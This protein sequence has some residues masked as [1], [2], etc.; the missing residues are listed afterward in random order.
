MQTTRLSSR[1]SLL[2]VLTIALF[3]VTVGVTVLWMGMQLNQRAIADSRKMIK[4]GIDDLHRQVAV[5]AIDYSI[6][7]T[8]YNV[9]IARDAAQI[10]E[11]F[12]S[13]ATYGDAF[14]LLALTD[15]PFEGVQSWIAEGPEEP[16]PD[17]VPEP[18]IAEARRLVAEIPLG[19]RTTAKFF[20][21]VGD[22]VYAFV[23]ARVQPHEM[24]AAGNPATETMPLAVFGYAIGEEALAELA[25][26][27]LLTDLRLTNAAP[28]GL[29]SLPLIGSDGT[30][31]AHVT[32]SPPTPGDALLERLG[33]PLVAVFL[34][35][36][37]IAG[38][39]TATARRNARKLIEQEARAHRA[40]RTDS[41]TVLPNRLALTEAM[42][43]AEDEAGSLAL[44]FMDINGFK[45]VN[46]TVGHKGGDELIAQ[47]SERLCAIQPP[48][49][50]LGR[51]SGD[52]FVMMVRGED[53]LKRAMTLGSQ[54]R[55]MLLPEFLVSGRTFHITVAIGVSKRGGE[56]DTAAELLRKADLAMYH[57]KRHGSPEPT[58]Y[59]ATFES[60]ARQKK[61]V[62]EAL[63]R[64]LHQPDDFVVHYHP[65]VDAHDGRMVKA[66]A[67][68]RWS[69]DTLGRIEPGVFITVAEETGLI[70]PLGKILIQKI[71]QDLTEWPELR[72]A[73]N[74]SPA[75]LNDAEF[76]RETIGTLREMNV[77]PSRIEIELT[78]GLIV[79]N[80]DMAAF[81]LDLLHEAGFATSLDDFGTGFS[82]I[83]YLK[84][85]PFNTLKIDKSFVP[86][87]PEDAHA[88]KMVHAI[89]MLGHSLGQTVVCEGIETGEQAQVLRDVGCD[90]L[91]G[92]H[93]ARPMPITALRDFERHRF[94]ANTD[95]PAA[96][97]GGG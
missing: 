42:N 30:A 87:D 16:Q 38:T 88:L 1:I 61:I 17:L 73:I 37:V 74:V 32:W 89:V 75:Q 36:T 78:E 64:S 54:V 9:M 44:V 63:R 91:Q 72:V 65:I 20:A 8:A 55:V 28:E 35:F 51:V 12:A 10:Y 29:P 21:Q 94:A 25:G 22:T 46:D 41:L 15:G 90:L 76:V 82:S 27:Y 11:Q 79:S 14:H 70:I 26:R 50:F 71:C 84:R 81:K 6:W 13:G 60:D 59:D 67:L 62:E 24:E 5:T 85:M 96:A 4:G 69:S 80:A 34:V 57:A 93:F 92:F 2:M 43:A 77:E 33:L 31:V 56:A 66:E 48:A 3:L 83:G 86:Q 23:G 53:A 18:V 97:S 7:D 39:V 49:D 58:L 40:A 52:E 45:R 47:M 19:A 95:A 68:A